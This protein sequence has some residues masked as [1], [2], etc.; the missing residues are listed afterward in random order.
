M[1]R[2]Q[3]YKGMLQ[4]KTLMVMVQSHIILVPDSRH[5]F[6]TPVTGEHMKIYKKVKPHMFSLQVD[7]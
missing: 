5:V 4:R 3:K 2:M 6:M 7:K 1:L